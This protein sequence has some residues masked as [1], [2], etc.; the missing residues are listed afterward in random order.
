[1]NYTV[2]QKHIR[3]IN[4]RVILNSIINTDTISRAALSRLVRMSKSAMTEYISSLLEMGIIKEIGEGHSTPTGGR[5]PI[6]LKFNKNYKYIIAI[7]LSFE[8]SIFVLS[9]LGGEIINKISK[10]VDS[11]SS[12]ADRFNLVK[13]TINKLISMQNL[14]HDDIAIIAISSPGVF[15]PSKEFIANPQFAN[16]RMNQL[17]KEL[18]DYF[19][20]SVLV[21]NDV[22]AAA[23]G[24]LKY[25]IG[26]NVDN[27]AYISCGLGIGAGIIINGSLYEGAT[28]SAGEIGN[29]ITP[30]KKGFASL[31]SSIN[32]NALLRYISE[33]APKHTLNKIMKITN[34]S[35]FGFKNVVSVWQT[36]DKFLQDCILKIAETLGYVISDIV[37]LLNCDLVILGGEYQVFK[38]AM[39]PLINRI[40]EE[41]AFY[42]VKVVPSSMQYPGIY[43]LFALSYEIILDH[44]SNASP[45]NNINV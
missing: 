18:E 10:N 28:K 37:S 16:W 14:K 24:E 25:G 36:G 41:N 2:D 5:K 15:I 6:L 19:H 35:K 8:D 31:E 22:N 42:P 34:S 17:T 45:K 30:A 38:S 33:E 13:D 40:V 21:V 12:Y 43:G 26:S 44:L 20:T 27:L 32:I 7:D 11:A 4:Q 3:S 9:N 23:V 29:F 1:L 39:L